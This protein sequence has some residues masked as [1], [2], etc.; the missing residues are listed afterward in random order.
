[1]DM[2]CRNSELEINFH[3]N[4][5]RWWDP[6]QNGGF[7]SLQTHWPHYYKYRARPKRKRKGSC[8]LFRQRERKR[9]QGIRYITYHCPLLHAYF[10]TRNPPWVAWKLSVLG[11]SLTPAPVLLG[12]F[13]FGPPIMSYSLIPTYKL[14]AVSIR[15]KQG[16]SNRPPTYFFLK[17][18]NSKA[19]WIFSFKIFIYFKYKNFI[20]NII[21]KEYNFSKTIIENLK[22]AFVSPE[23]TFRKLFY[24]FVCAWQL[25]KI[26]SM[27]NHLR[28]DWKISHFERKIIYALILPSNNFRKPHLKRESLSTLLTRSKTHLQA[29]ATPRSKTHLQAYLQT[30]SWRK[31]KKKKKGTEP[32]ERERGRSPELEIDSTTI[33]AVPLTIDLPYFSLPPS[34][35]HVTDLPFF[36]LPM[37]SKSPQEEQP[38]VTQS[39]PPR[40]L[41]PPRD[42]ASAD[43]RL[44]PVASLFLPSS[45]NL[46]GFVEIFFLLGFVFVVFIY[47]EMILYIC[48]KAEKMWAT[49]RKC[50]FY[51]I[52]KNTTKH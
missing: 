12:L 47:W 15:Y 25:R 10:E 9:V 51:S 38:I 20:A 48:L 36:S 17:Y 16:C 1:M 32:R 11:P 8:M 22:V 34:A 44:N 5:N 50:V 43:S 7:S 31:K 52:F 33:W 3:Y 26:W 23:N 19:N 40:I 30:I 13:L 39:P 37:S 24:T 45:L 41:P 28:F 2:I 21:V 42:L 35:T 14:V 18:N 4:S 27:E 6:C 29:P 49:S 46:T